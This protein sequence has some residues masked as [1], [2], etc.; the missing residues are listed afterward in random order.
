MVLWALLALVGAAILTPWIYIAGKDLAAYVIESQK[1][2]VELSGFIESLGGSCDR[3][4]VGRYFSRAL[5][6][7]FL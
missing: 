1:N 4:E 6:F 5:M 2:G 3:A 7:S